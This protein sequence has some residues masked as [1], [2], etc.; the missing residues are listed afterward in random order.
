MQKI[1]PH[2]RNT[3]RIAGTHAIVYNTMDIASGFFQIVSLF[4]TL[5]IHYFL[6]VFYK[7]R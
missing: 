6:Y 1:K 2:S 4:E 5:R 3:P 7:A